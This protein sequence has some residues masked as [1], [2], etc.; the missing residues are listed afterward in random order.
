M[1]IS[2]EEAEKIGKDYLKNKYTTSNKLA[3]SGFEERD[4]CWIFCYDTKK[5]IETLNFLD[6]M[7]G[8]CPIV[9]SKKTG[10]IKLLGIQDDLD[11][12]IAEFEK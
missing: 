12:L 6:A 7:L 4:F 8:N 1:S 3:I 9:I 2:F 10:E 11:E 5:Y